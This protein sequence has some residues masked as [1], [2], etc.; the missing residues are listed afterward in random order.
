MHSKNGAKVMNPETGIAVDAPACWIIAYGNVQRGDD[1]IGPLVA[2]K[3]SLH[4]EFA[5]EV[6]IRELPQLDLGL[7]EEIQSAET[8]IFVDASVE[9]LADDVQWSR[10]KPE[11]NGWAMGSHN[12]DPKV[13][14]GLLKLLY[15]STTDVW[16]VSVQGYEFELGEPVSRRAYRSADKAA[17][18]IVDWLFK[19]NIALPH[20]SIVKED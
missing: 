17:V 7:L 14:T 3:L 12:I 1:G 4:Y 5:H 6:G 18:Q 2:R 9:A 13:F 10:V 20:K 8:I 15:N 19:Q 16:L 11:L